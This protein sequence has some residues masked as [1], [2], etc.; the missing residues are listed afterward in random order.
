[1]SEDDILGFLDDDYTE[2]STEVK[3]TKAPWT[4]NQILINAMLD[5]EKTKFFMLKSRLIDFIRW[6][7]YLTY[8]HGYTVRKNN[9]PPMTL[10]DGIRMH[11]TYYIEV[12]FGDFIGAYRNSPGVVDYDIVIAAILDNHDIKEIIKEHS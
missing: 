7:G 6:H 4:K 1:M 8:D 12:N 3:P 2:P 9:N 11:L 5:K 10:L